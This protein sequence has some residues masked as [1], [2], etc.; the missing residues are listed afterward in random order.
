MISSLQRTLPDNTHRDNRQTYTPPR[1]IRTR[2][3]IKRA[4]AP[5]TPRRHWDPR[6]HKDDKIAD[7][8]NGGTCA[9]YR[10]EQKCKQNFGGET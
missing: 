2:N 4:V 6:Y 10:R 1:D 3:P 9:M 7:D 5:F 8:G